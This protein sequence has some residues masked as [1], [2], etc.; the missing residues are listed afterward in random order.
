[1]AATLSKPMAAPAKFKVPYIDLKAQ[2]R[3]LKKE[4]FSAIGKILDRGDFILGENVAELEGRFAKYCGVRYA[5]GVNSGTDAL[6]LA[7]KA[8]AIGPGDEIITCPN[9]FLATASA[10]VAIGAKPVFVD[11]RQDM[12][13][14]PAQIEAKI[15]SRTKAIIPVHLTGKP[16]DM[17]PILAIAKKRKLHV[18]EDAAQAI[19]TEYK[20]KRAGS[21]GAMSAFSMHPL[22]TLNASGDGGMMTTDDENL[23]RT[24]QQLRNIGLKNRSESDIWGMNSR[25]D[26]IQAAIVGIKFKHVDSWIKKRRKNADVYRELLGGIVECPS[27]NSAVEK[28]SYHLFVIQG[29]RRDE[30]QAHLLKNGI[31]TKIHYPLPIHLQKCASE[32]GYKRGDFPVVERQAQRI[33]SIPVH[34]YLTEGQLE[35]VAKKIKEFYKG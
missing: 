13:I 23:Y 22:K 14:D 30:L 10:A 17:D 29:D 27:E 33:L 5:I 4:I 34:Q 18:I 35:Y 25:L 32:L 19:G 9:S 8:L 3:A 31:D 28:H 12:N 21:F 1:M 11:A 15:T 24:V 2:H 26:T 16:A 6:M 20:G 7:M